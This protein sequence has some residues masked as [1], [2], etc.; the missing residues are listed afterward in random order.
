MAKKK[1][2]G[3]PPVKNKRQTVGVTIKPRLVK[4]IDH[5]A[6]ALGLTRSATIEYILEQHFAKRRTVTSGRN[7]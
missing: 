3:R 7:Y 6:N 2:R 4:R 1:T 5:K